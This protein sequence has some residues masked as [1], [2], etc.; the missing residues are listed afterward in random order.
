MDK[1]SNISFRNSFADGI[2]KGSADKIHEFLAT[3]TIEKLEEKRKL[4]A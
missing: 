4:A 1:F 2:G 3:G